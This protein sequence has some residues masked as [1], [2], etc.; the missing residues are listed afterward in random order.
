MT[1][2][3]LGFNAEI[4]IGVEYETVNYGE[5]YSKN[6]L[7][8]AIFEHKPVLDTMF[9]MIKPEHGEGAKI[10]MNSEQAKAIRDVLDKYIKE[11]EVV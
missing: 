6:G 11:I 2:H 3:A 4:M 10:V 7:C 8:Y 9:I 1:E 5:S